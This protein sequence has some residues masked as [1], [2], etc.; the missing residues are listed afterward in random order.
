MKKSLI[1]GREVTLYSDG[2]VEW[3]TILKSG[4][5]RVWRTKGTKTKN[6]YKAVHINGKRYSVHRLIAEAFIPNPEN[7]PFIDH[8]NTIRDDNRVQNLRWCTYEE[9]QNNPLTLKKMSEAKKGNTN[10][11]KK[12]IIGVHNVSGEVREFESV[13]DA[14]LTLNI[15][16]GNISSCLTGR[17]KSTVGWHFEYKVA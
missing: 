1:N 12:P 17:L 16:Q 7:K 3:L 10:C 14:A 11:P 15:N 13:S 8:I 2:T 9:N 4:R 5:K 6:G